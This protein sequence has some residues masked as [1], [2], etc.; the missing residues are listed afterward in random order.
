M[1]SYTFNLTY[2]N[3][4]YGRISNS[5]GRISVSSCEDEICSYTFEKFISD[6]CKSEGSHMIVTVFASNILGDSLPSNSSS[7]GMHNN[8]QQLL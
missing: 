2:S 8:L 7:I 3:S 6:L 1:N 5:Y 4:K